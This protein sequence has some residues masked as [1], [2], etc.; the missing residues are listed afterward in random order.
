MEFEENNNLCILDPSGIDISGN[1]KLILN[2]EGN[3][4]ANDVSINHLE[5]NGKLFPDPPTGTDGQILK[6]NN[7]DLIWGEDTAA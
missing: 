5:L 1:G 6:I 4:Y 7:G 3:I 2:S